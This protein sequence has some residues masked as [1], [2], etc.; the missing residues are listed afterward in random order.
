MRIRQSKVL[1]SFDRNI[2]ILD[3]DQRQER[4]NFFDRS[5]V[6]CS[7][8]RLTVLGRRTRQT[9][10]LDKKKERKRSEGHPIKHLREIFLVESCF[11]LCLDAKAN[12]VRSSKHL[13][14]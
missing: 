3:W 5:F 8:D 1:L 14:L 11:S 2:Y 10:K 13:F 9:G 4:R 7:C 6:R 12:Q